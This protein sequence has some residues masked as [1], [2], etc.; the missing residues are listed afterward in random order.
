MNQPHQSSQKEF[1]LLSAQLMAAYR[2]M[3]SERS[4]RLFFDPFAAQLATPEAKAIALEDPED[5]DAPYVNVRTRFFDDFLTSNVS[6]QVVILGAGMDTRAFRLN[7]ELGTKVFE[8]DYP[9]IFDF[10]SQIL[11]DI[12]TKCSRYR[13]PVDLTKFWSEELLVQGYDKTKSSIWLL[14]GLLYFLSESEVHALLKTIHN[15]TAINSYLGL[16]LINKSC[17]NSSG[18]EF[19]QE[20]FL[21]GCDNPEELLASYDWD[22]E[23]FQPGDKE[24]HF[25]RYTR[26]SPARNNYEVPQA[27]F[28]KAKKNS[29]KFSSY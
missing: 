9:E 2:A 11:K 18:E 24:A 29:N 23:V 14:E 7:W 27:F 6:S 26:K 12:P 10:K 13:V 20:Y 17:M 19:Y 4:D 8:L 21:F 25:G 28:V 3:E 16:D 1:V 5:E 15:L 22:A